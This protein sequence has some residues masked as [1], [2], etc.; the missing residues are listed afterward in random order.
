MRR[1]HLVSILVF[2]G[3]ILVMT[4]AVTG[5][6]PATKGSLAV[7]IAG[8]HNGKHVLL[9]K[10]QGICMGKSLKAKFYGETAKPI[11]GCWKPIGNNIIQVVF[12]DGD[13]ATIPMAAFRKPEE[14]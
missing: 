1:D 4:A 13:F 3:G 14:L 2:V 5:I 7:A 9:Y 8:D 12:L 6:P 11:E 10:E